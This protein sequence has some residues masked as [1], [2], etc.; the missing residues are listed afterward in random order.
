MTLPS[1]SS[2]CQ[3]PWTRPHSSPPLGHLPHTC[4]PG[5]SSPCTP[6]LAREADGSLQPLPQRHVDT[7]MGLERLVAVLQGRRSTYDTDLF[8]PLLSAIHQVSLPIRFQKPL[9]LRV[10]GAHHY[11]FLSL[12][13]TQSIP[14]CGDGD[15]PRIPGCQ[16]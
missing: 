11:C 13:K 6:S 14:S 15:Q 8:S 2:H 10:T 5:G 1:G 9:D 4:N 7:G 16:T 12:L 3:P